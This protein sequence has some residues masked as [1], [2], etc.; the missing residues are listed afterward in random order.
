MLEKIKTIVE[1]EKLSKGFCVKVGRHFKLR[2][3]KYSGTVL[4]LGAINVAGRDVTALCVWTHGNRKNV[5]GT[6][7]IYGRV[8]KGYVG[9]LHV[10]RLFGL[11]AMAYNLQKGKV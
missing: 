10:N 9:F 5:H 4:H 2:Y 7:N 6:V 11:G 8:Y 3:Q 1:F